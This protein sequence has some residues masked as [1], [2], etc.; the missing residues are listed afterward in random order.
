[1]SARDLSAAAS[2]P[3]KEVYDHLDHVQSSGHDFRLVVEPS[4]CR[5]CGFVFGKRDRL[6][7][8]GKC[9]VCR[10]ESISPPLFSLE[11]R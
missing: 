10:G 3:E 1:M 4:V 6:T 11:P 5:S 2:I 9:P 7:K 8:P